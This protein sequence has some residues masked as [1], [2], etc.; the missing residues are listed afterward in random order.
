MT[1]SRTY[2]H[3]LADL[4]RESLTNPSGSCIPK[5][6]W[7]K[8]EEKNM[9]SVTNIPFLFF[10]LPLSFFLLPLLS[11]AKMLQFQ[12]L[13]KLSQDPVQTPIP[14]SGTPVQLT[15]LSCPESTPEKADTVHMYVLE[16]RIIFLKNLYEAYWINLL[17]CLLTNFLSLQRVPDVAVKIIIASKDK[18]AWVGECHRCDTSIQ[19]GVLVTNDLLVRAQV[20]HL[21]AAVIWACND[22]VSTGEELNWRLKTYILMYNDDKHKLHIWINVFSY[23]G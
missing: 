12:S 17:I 19:T 8:E 10:F 13:R 1:V 15:L 9:R 22:S 21:A 20:I 23:Y 11:S 5:W 2:M 18:A 4:H 16:L 3:T 7:S 14:S 6:E